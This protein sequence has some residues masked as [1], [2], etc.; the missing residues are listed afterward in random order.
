MSSPASSVAIL[1]PA[2]DEALLA[3]IRNTLNQ[4]PRA[5]KWAFS[6]YG[7]AIRPEQ[8]S[9]VPAYDADTSRISQSLTAGSPGT[10]NIERSCRSILRLNDQTPERY[11]IAILDKEAATGSGFVRLRELCREQQMPLHCI[12]V[13]EPECN[14]DVA[15]R[16]PVLPA[17][18]A[19]RWWV[20]FAAALQESYR[21]CT[22]GWKNAG[23]KTLDSFLDLRLRH[24]SDTPVRFSKPA[25]LLG[26]PGGVR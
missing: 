11:M 15:R 22:P 9:Q 17:S 21:I 5:Q 4:K 20:D 25:R 6:A 23:G 13:N 8:Q 3:S 19:A 12:R 1:Y 7:Q 14:P 16:L 2:W 26:T 24:T 18:G 10:T